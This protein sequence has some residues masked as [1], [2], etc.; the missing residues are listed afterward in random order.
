M[1]T[2]I[3]LS[4]IMPFRKRKKLSNSIPG[5]FSFPS[6]YWE[7]VSNNAKDFIRHLL[8]TSPQERYSSSHLM[9]HTWLKVK[10]C[11]S[12]TPN[13]LFFYTEETICWAK[14]SWALKEVD[15]VFKQQ[16]S[17]E[18]LTSSSTHRKPLVTY[19]FF[20]KG[21]TLLSPLGTLQA[22][23]KLLHNDRNRDWF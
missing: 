21:T 15:R 2:Y 4:G 20:S 9:Q 8:V 19:S 13:Y 10:Q 3:L 7:S 14:R 6:V 23:S 18:S 16:S 17:N 5:K 1:I 12:V 22:R 11:I